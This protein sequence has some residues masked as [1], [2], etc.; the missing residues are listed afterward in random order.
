MKCLKL[1]GDDLPTFRLYNVLVSYDRKSENDES[2]EGECRGNI[3]HQDST[4]RLFNQNTF[5][6][7]SGADKHAMKSFLRYYYVM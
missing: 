4:H 1:L 7:G 2:R 5:K 6:G 3:Q